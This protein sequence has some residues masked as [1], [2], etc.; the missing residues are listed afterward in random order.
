LESIV[1]TRLQLN[2]HP[3]EQLE[4]NIPYL[5]NN[6]LNGM[7][8][9]Y[10]ETVLFFPSQGQT[11][12]AYCSFCFRWPQFVGI[13]DL[14]LASREVDTLIQ[15]VSQHPEVSDIL[16]TGGDPLIMKTSALSKHKFGVKYTLIFSYIKYFYYL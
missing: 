4:Y 8:H 2:P 3:A 1:K 14:K 12:H 6:P 7:Q 9:K 5:E 11:C 16:L 13:S 15:Y 10:K